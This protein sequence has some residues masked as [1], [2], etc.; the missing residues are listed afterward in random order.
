MTIE[1]ELTALAQFYSP[2]DTEEN[3]FNAQ[4][5]KEKRTQLEANF[6]KWISQ[7]LL[8]DGASKEHIAANYKKLIIYVHTDRKSTFSPALI[9][10]EHQLSDGQ[11]NGACCKILNLCYEKLTQPA[12]FKEIEFSGINSK[13]DC[14]LWLEQL[15][16]NAKSDTHR[17][18]YVHLMR[19]L[20]ESNNYFDTTGVIKPEALKVLVQFV[21]ATLATFGSILV[22][23]QLLAIYAIYFV[24]LKSGQKLE[25]SNYDELRKMGQAMEH[26]TSVTALKT[27]TLLIRIFEMLFWASRQCLAITLEVSS[28][29][30]TP[31][32]TAAKDEETMDVSAL[33]TDLTLSG[34]N[35]QGMKFDTPELKIIAAPFE[36]Y[37]ILNKQQFFGVFR[38]GNE[39][40][41]MVEAFLFRLR[42]YDHEA[43]SLETKYT[44]IL[45]ELEKIENNKAVHNGK[46]AQAVA[47]VR[48]IITVLKSP[49]IDEHL[50]T[51]HEL[52]TIDKEISLGA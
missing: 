23:E 7:K 25:R 22:I 41:K 3:R 44:Q 1:T 43:T 16:T 33:C 39:K 5:E 21:P 12:K 52:K 40:Y 34:A 18:L 27:T 42:V 9:W 51:D 17:N 31:L 14:K 29:F 32:I 2:F 13:E 19:L 10:L 30:F 36:K 35:H 48:N 26:Y 28:R 45:N 49:A 47:Y 20:D 50:L 11:N 37:L 46:T 6:T 8:T 24:I 4:L 15:I 38:L